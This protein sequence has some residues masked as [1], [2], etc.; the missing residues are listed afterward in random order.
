[1]PERCNNS[2]PPGRTDNYRNAVSAPKCL[3]ERRSGAFRHHYTTG[4]ESATQSPQFYVSF[5]EKLLKIVATNSE[6]CRLMNSKEGGMGCD[7]IIGG[8]PNVTVC[9]RGESVSFVAK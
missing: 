4:Y 2:V 5:P 9:D 6:I 8:L 7:I 3:P 1:L